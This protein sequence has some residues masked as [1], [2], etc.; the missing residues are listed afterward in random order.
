M[1]PTASHQR[2]TITIL[3][4]G[5]RRYHSRNES[6]RAFVIKGRTT[7]LRHCVTRCIPRMASWRSLELS[8]GSSKL[9]QHPHT[10]A[11]A[12]GSRT[13]HCGGAPAWSFGDGAP[14]R[15]ARHGRLP[16]A[17][18][19]GTCGDLRRRT[20]HRQVRAGGCGIRAGWPAMG[21]ARLANERPAPVT[22]LARN[23]HMTRAPTA[24]CW[25]DGKPRPAAAPDPT[26]P[27]RGQRAHLGMH[28]AVQGRSLRQGAI[29]CSDA[30]ACGGGSG[31]HSGAV[32]TLQ[33]AEY[34]IDT[35]LATDAGVESVDKD[36]GM[37]GA[38]DSQS[39]CQR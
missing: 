12:M 24:G 35:Y 32:D 10:A 14:A 8:Q 3:G 36:D 38:L 15:A 18:T 25:A 33:K 27:L 34:G 39:C 1:A 16:S 9:T 4:Q 23:E 17:R 26:A 30:S 6:V 31:G 19:Q 21:K 29:S 2:A 20:V 11:A 22:A 5:H 28:D 7:T 13:H 37:T